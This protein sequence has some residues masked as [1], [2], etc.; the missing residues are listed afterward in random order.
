MKAADNYGKRA[1]SYGLWDGFGSMN[2]AYSYQLLI[3]NTAF[4]RGFFVSG[5]TGCY[6]YCDSWCGD[7]TSP[8]FRTSSTTGSLYKGVAFNI[9]G[10]QTYVLNKRLMSVGLR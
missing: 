6:K 10:H 7:T 1:D 5:Y 4:Y 9:N 8:Y 3:C 2:S